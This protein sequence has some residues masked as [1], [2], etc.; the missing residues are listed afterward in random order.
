MTTLYKLG[1][2]NIGISV[3]IVNENEVS[4]WFCRA[5]VGNSIL[6]TVEYPYTENDQPSDIEFEV[7]RLVSWELTRTVTNLLWGN[8]STRTDVFVED[9]KNES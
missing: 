4:K 3:S 9:E 2:T 1:D 7:C 5:Y 8:D 6:T